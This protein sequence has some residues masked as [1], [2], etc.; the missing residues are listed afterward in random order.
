MSVPRS[1]RR[2]NRERRE[3]GGN[4]GGWSVFRILNINFEFEAVVAELHVRITERTQAL[5][6]FCMREFMSDVREPS[7]ARLEEIDEGQGLFDR[8]VHGMRRIAQRVNDEVAE[9]L[10]ERHRGFGDGTEI[11][12][13]RGI[14]KPKA[15]HG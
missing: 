8:L 14:A 13:I 11:S 10:Q 5:V 4:T 7:A 2:K 6:G 15:E 3:L 12:E 9:I 1:R